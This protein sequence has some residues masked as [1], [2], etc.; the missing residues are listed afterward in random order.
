ML[1]S[2]KSK[3]NPGNR[4]IFFMNHIPNKGLVSRICKELSQLNNRK[5]NMPMF[6]LASNINRYFSKDV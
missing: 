5:T 6:R 3:D 4:R 1:P 2:R